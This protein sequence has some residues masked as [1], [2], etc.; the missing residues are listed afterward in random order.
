MRNKCSK[1]KMKALLIVKVIEKLNNKAT[2]N[3]KYMIFK[4]LQNNNLTR[5]QFEVQYLKYNKTHHME[6]KPKG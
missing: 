5:C 3:K 1:V 4:I 6:P 2:E